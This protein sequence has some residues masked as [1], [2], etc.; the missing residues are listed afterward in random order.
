[1]E[2]STAPGS[3]SSLKECSGCEGNDSSGGE[4]SL[5][6]A[7]GAIVPAAALEHLAELEKGTTLAWLER[8]NG[9][10]ARVKTQAAEYLSRV[11]LPLEGR[12][13]SGGLEDT[14]S[15][16][17][18]AWHAALGLLGRPVPLDELP[19]EEQISYLLSDFQRDITALHEIRQE[20]AERNCE[21]GSHIGTMRATVRDAIPRL[22]KADAEV[23]ALVAAGGEPGV[24]FL[25]ARAEL[26]AATYAYNLAENVL[27]TLRVYRNN[28]DV[29][30]DEAEA[31]SSDITFAVEAVR[32]R[33]GAA[34]RRSRGGAGA[35][36]EQKASA[37]KAVLQ[38]QLTKAVPELERAA[39]EAEAYRARRDTCEKRLTADKEMD[40]EEKFSIRE[41]YEILRGQWLDARAALRANTYVKHVL[42]LHLDAL[43]DALDD[44]LETAEER[45]ARESLPGCCFSGYE[46][47]K[48]EVSPLL[49]PAEKRVGEDS[50]E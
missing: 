36:Y 9:E 10:L 37:F 44:A 45:E 42:D 32:C 33:Y 7:I 47:L 13:A 49:V 22:K 15:P 19:V 5:Y 50:M 14:R 41:E 3:E 31:L 38:E 48:S 35:E 39:E 18:K 1:M 21:T 4:S 6:G 2:E 11:M 46:V 40:V 29:V 23:S 26:R 30:K 24:G 17:R 8:T 20:L 34:L 16:L 28:L 43:D 12:L 27:E 25:E